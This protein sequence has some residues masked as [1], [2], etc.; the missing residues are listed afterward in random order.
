MAEMETEPTL[1]STDSF[2]APTPAQST[3]SI[4]PLQWF[5]VLALD[6][7]LAVSLTCLTFTLW[8]VLCFLTQQYSM[9]QFLPLPHQAL[10]ANASAWDMSP[11]ELSH[12]GES[13]T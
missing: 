4:V 5:R 13:I 9:L 1:Y 10:V 8:T 2:S 6:V 7:D 12:R 3:R 11:D